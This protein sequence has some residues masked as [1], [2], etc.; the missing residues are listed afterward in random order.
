[1]TRRFVIGG[2]AVVAVVVFIFVSI[3]VLNVSRGGTAPS[4][5]V[6]PQ[7]TSTFPSATPAQ[8]IPT[9]VPTNT[10]DVTAKDGSKLRVH[11]VRL[12]PGVGRIDTDSNGAYF[13]MP[14]KNPAQTSKEEGYTL[15]FWQKTET[16][17]IT[18]TGEP[19]EER[20]KVA[21]QD[22]LSRLG[23]PK[24]DFCRLRF[25]ISVTHDDGTF[26][27]RPNLYLCSQ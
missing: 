7:A 11:D 2:F 22:L 15:A 8:V 23:V 21:E 25:Y 24:D 14:V 27:E 4:N 26:I 13:I 9:P 5:S 3:K 20:Q 6:S 18:I 17:T 12:D 10:M 19:F 16:F 1:M